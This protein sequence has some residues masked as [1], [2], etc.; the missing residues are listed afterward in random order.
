LPVVPKGNCLP[1]V[2]ALDKITKCR[3]QYTEQK[4]KR[5]MTLNR[6]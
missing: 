5:M 4:L 1:L 6:I 2:I 3:K